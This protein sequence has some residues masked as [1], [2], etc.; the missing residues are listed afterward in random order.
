M[1]V[2]FTAFKILKHI[3]E[4]EKIDFS[5]NYYSKLNKNTFSN[6]E[7]S[8]LYQLQFLEQT[9][10]VTIVFFEEF[11][12][13]L[14]SIIDENKSFFIHFLKLR[15]IS[16][17]L[18]QSECLNT[19]NDFINHKQRFISKFYD[20]FQFIDYYFDL[21]YTFKQ[22]IESKCFIEFSIINK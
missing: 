8:G 22:S 9:N 3:A 6:L 15:K 11:K 21:I 16:F 18:N 10:N 5:E 14:I 17:I 4:N 12:K 20:Q 19:Y 2:K 1:E 7:K 13:L